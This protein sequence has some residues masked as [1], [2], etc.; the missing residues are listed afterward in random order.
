MRLGIPGAPGAG[1]STFI[2]AFGTYLTA[3]GHKVAVLAI[4]P[5]LPE[6][7]AIRGLLHTELLDFSAAES[8]LKRAIELNPNYA[9][10]HMWL[11]MTL[12]YQGL[13]GHPGAYAARMRGE[14]FLHGDTAGA[15]EVIQRHRQK[16]VRLNVP[17]PDV[18]FDVDTPEDLRIALDPGA[19]WARVQ[20]EADE[21]RAPRPR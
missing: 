19:R 18:C 6:A 16:T 21:R 7:Y 20:R 1:K 2:E 10:A 14:F 13:G 8:D 9:N 4:D 5:S 15:R 12:N 11:G 3:Q 17:D